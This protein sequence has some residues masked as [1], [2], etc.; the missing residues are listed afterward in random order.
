MMTRRVRLA[1]RIGYLG[2]YFHGSQIQPDVITVQSELIRVMASLNWIDPKDNGLLILS[3]R[4]DAGVHVRVNGGTVEIDEELWL[5]IGRRKFVRA[6]DDRLPK[7]LALL[8]VHRVEEG[9]NARLALHRCYR[10]RLECLEGW[11]EPEIDEFKQI[12]SNFIGTYDAR[13]FAKMEPHRNPE[14]TIIDCKPWLVDNRIVGFEITGYA[15]LWN[16]VR[17]TA[18]AIHRVLIGEISIQDIKRA[19]KQP[20][21]EVDFGVAPPQWLVLWNIEWNILPELPTQGRDIAFSIPPVAEMVERT[22]MK[23]WRYACSQEMKAMLH[24]EWAVLGILPSPYIDHRKDAELIL[25]SEQSDGFPSNL[26]KTDY[27]RS[28]ES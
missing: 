11:S 5:S 22:M 15:F 17:R 1:F 19:I 6:I 7:Q 3:S 28:T 4:T 16:Q 27:N 24:N 18:F 14:R 25:K 9:W 23:R 13:N 2:D 21:T 10:Y 26:K 8:D 12:L 20:E